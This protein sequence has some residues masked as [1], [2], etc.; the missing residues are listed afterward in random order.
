M[1]ASSGNEAATISMPP[2]LPAQ[3]QAVAVQEHRMA[4][5]IARKPVDRSLSERRWRR[6]LACGEERAKTS[7]CTYGS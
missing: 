4:D 6:I 7:C 5:D 1:K 3:A 2:D